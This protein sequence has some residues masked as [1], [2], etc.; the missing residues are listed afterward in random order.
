MSPLRRPKTMLKATVLT[1]VAVLSLSTAA[2]ANTL[3]VGDRVTE[4]DVAVDAAGKPFKLKALK[5]K[6]F[7]ITVGAAWCK[8]CAKEL[9]QWDKIAAARA[10]KVTFVA[11]DIDDDVAD[12]KRFH[13]KLKI[14][15]MTKVYLPND[16]S[17]VGGNYGSD[18]MPTSFIVDP[19]GV[20]RHV[21]KGFNAGDEKSLAAELDK[22]VK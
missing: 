14:K 2:Q 19:Q 22:L 16:K 5:G 15:N 9:P 1:V 7:V 8:P 3:K 10:G 4:L 6:W 11:V 18:T 12:G 20:V 17:S 13:E 21:H